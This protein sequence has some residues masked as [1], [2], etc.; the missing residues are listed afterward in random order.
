MP[1]MTAAR[2]EPPGGYPCDV[3]VTIDDPIGGQS[4]RSEFPHA[5]LEQWG[6]GKGWSDAD[7]QARML[8][9]MA[10]DR[11]TSSDPDAP[12]PIDAG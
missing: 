9:T 6:E 5:Q 1:I 2:F 7:Y 4:Q 10:H 11:S 8:E 12:P 3:T